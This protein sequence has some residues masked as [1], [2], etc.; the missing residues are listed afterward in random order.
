[1]N[2]WT[3]TPIVWYFQGNP[4]LIQKS[5][6]CWLVEAHEMK[7]NPVDALAS[8]ELARSNGTWV[9]LRMRLTRHW[10][11]EDTLLRAGKEDNKEGRGWNWLSAFCCRQNADLTLT[12]YLALLAAYRITPGPSFRVSQVFFFSSKYTINTE[13]ACWLVRLWYNR[14]KSLP[15]NM[16]VGG[17][18]GFWGSSLRGK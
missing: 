15:F 7:S 13:V 1:M 6:F 3:L 18:G 4:I 9:I 10:P 11:E 14:P 5:L 12:S 17:T 8:N 16:Y 2:H